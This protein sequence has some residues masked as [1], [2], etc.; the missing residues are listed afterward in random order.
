MIEP[1]LGVLAWLAG[2]WLA[3]TLRE[4]KKLKVQVNLERAEEL[5]NLALYK[6]DPEFAIEL[7]YTPSETKK[8]HSRLVR[9]E[10]TQ[11]LSPG[12]S[13]LQAP[14]TMGALGGLLGGGLGLHQ[15]QQQQ[16]NQLMQ[17]AAQDDM[18]W[19]QDLMAQ[20]QTRNPDGTFTPQTLAMFQ[21]MQQSPRCTCG[22][23]DIADPTFH[24]GSCAIWRKH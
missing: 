9:G 8:L 15:Q 10:F 3:R 21:A 24:H 19:Q 1:I 16:R 12:L 13:A 23:P 17:Q 7:G 5:A 22:A 11:L 20:R 4:R 14:P 6:V 2:S 18:R